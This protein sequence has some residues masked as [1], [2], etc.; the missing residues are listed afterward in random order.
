MIKRKNK[1]KPSKYE[2]ISQPN[3]Q[4]WSISPQTEN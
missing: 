4:V 3:R 2:N 1:N